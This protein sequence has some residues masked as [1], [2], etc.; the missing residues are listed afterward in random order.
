MIDL[1]IAI[2]IITLVQLVIVG[3]IIK[4]K[5]PN[6]FTKDQINGYIT[7]SAVG[8]VPVMNLIAFTIVVLFIALLMIVGIAK[9]IQL[10]IGNENK[11]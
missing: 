5:Y 1:T 8:L 7:I 9:L 11:Q 4:L 6:R 10:V 2:S 3:S